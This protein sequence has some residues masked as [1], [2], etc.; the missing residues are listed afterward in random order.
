MKKKD[1]DTKR[2]ERESERV[3]ECVC[4]RVRECVTSS[5][6]LFSSFQSRLLFLISLR[7]HAFS[8]A[9]FSAFESAFFEYLA[10]P[11]HTIENAPV[12]CRV[13]VCVCVSILYV[14]YSLSLSKHHTNPH[15]HT[16]KTH[17]HTQIAS[18]FFFLYML[19]LLYVCTGRKEK[20]T[21]SSMVK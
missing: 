1:D 13:C 14:H 12:P 20:H 8:L 9:L 6:T 16:H 21:R 18:V 3:R 5:R 17:T 11:R 2:S 19:M 7:A 4:E 10:T 15:T